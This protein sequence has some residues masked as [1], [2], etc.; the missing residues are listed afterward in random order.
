MDDAAG[1]TGGIT[2]GGQEGASPCAAIFVDDAAGMILEGGREENLSPSHDKQ[3][4]MV[5]PFAVAHDIAGS[6]IV[7]LTCAR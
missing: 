2:G 6:R 1:M 3:S 7:A 5:S 4:S